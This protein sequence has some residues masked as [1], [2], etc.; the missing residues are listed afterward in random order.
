MRNE[1]TTA[2]ETKLDNTKAQIEAVIDSN[3]AKA[4]DVLTRKITSLSETE[5]NLIQAEFQMAKYTDFLGRIK[6]YM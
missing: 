4:A 3:I 5:R 2:I 1:T 6:F